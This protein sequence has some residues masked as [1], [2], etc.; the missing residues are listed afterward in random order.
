M[1]YSLNDTNAAGVIGQGGMLMV[2]SWILAI[3]AALMLCA[4]CGSVGK[5]LGKD[6]ATADDAS[7]GSG[8]TAGSVDT[9]GKTGSTD[10]AGKAGTTQPSQECIDE[11]SKCADDSGLAA[12]PGGA[13]ASGSG[14]TSKPLLALT[15]CESMTGSSA[16]KHICIAITTKN[17]A[18]CGKFTD[19]DTEHFVPE[20]MKARCE[21]WVIAAMGKPAMCDNL[22]YVF[23]TKSK[24]QT[25][26]DCYRTLAL[27]TKEKSLC[28]KAEDPAYCEKEYL[29]WNDA[30]STKDCGGDDTCLLNYA[31]FHKDKKACDEVSDAFKLAC[32]V[33]LSGDTQACRQ[34]KDLDFWYYCDLRSHFNEM[35]PAKDTYNFGPCGKIHQCYKTIMPYLVHSIAT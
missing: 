35:M 32:Q 1:Q 31:W 2:K 30:A 34:I 25:K 24:E 13:G 10:A 20:E 3:M 12:L 33:S 5:M 15:G 17:V 21:W 4:A 26:A 8:A 16:W 28:A 7:N 22:K 14:S 11:P 18:E 9:A 29:M 19:A 23:P 6:R 27:T